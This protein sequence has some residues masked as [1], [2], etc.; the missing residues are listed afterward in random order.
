MF[1]NVFETL[2]DGAK[3]LPEPI[4]TPIFLHPPQSNF[5]KYKQDVVAKVIFM[6][7]SMINELISKPCAAWV[8]VSLP[9]F[10]KSH[11]SMQWLGS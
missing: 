5:T 2:S 3:S 6:H 8:A 10:E 1:R 9:M 4:F 11:V 7:M